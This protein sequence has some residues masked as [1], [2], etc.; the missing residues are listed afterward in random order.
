[1][2]WNIVSFHFL[3]TYGFELGF[4]GR[5]WK[6]MKPISIFGVGLLGRLGLG[7]FVKS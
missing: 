1:M 7:H 6:C 2:A 3:I 4:N 5:P